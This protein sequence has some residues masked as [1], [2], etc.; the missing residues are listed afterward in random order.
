MTKFI[1]KGGG[2]ELLVV[3]NLF[4]GGC[5]AGGESWGVSSPMDSG[6]G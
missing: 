5:L 4:G 2:R 6:V 1:S 3:E